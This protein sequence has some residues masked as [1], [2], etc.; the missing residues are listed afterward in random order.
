MLNIVD[1]FNP[2]S[3]G[4]GGD[5]K[6]GPLQ[7]VHE[8]TELVGF[9]GFNLRP[10]WFSVLRQGFASICINAYPFYSVSS[11]ERLYFPLVVVRYTKPGLR[12]RTHE[13]IS[14]LKVS[15]RAAA[16][17]PRLYINISPGFGTNILDL[18]NSWLQFSILEDGRGVAG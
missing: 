1:D 10:A 9:P 8:C 2:L 4:I 7:F 11:P 6:W 18:V 3:R 16:Y 17:A 15:G 5:R 14:L 12:M 13:P